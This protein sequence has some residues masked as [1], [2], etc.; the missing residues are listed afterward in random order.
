MTPRDRAAS[1]R[2]TP[3]HY[4]IF[5][6]LCKRMRPS[7]GG[8]IR[9]LEGEG[10]RVCW[11]HGRA[12]WVGGLPPSSTTAGTLIERAAAAGYTVTHF[13]DGHCTAERWGQI[14]RLGDLDALRNWLAQVT[15]KAA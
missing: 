8:T 7:A 11:R 5:C 9:L 4:A 3:E 2:S 12:E 1:R 13:A 6:A 14:V 10:K 15:G